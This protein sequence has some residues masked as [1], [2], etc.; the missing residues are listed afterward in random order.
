MRKIYLFI[1]IVMLGMIACKKQSFLDDKTS[2]LVDVNAVFSDSAR[3]IA[4]LNR[5]YEEMP[6]IF[7][8][9]RWEGGNTIIGTD[10]AESNLGNP[11]RRSVALYLANYSQ[12]NFP[13]HDAWNTPW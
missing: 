10:D 5:M 8:Y 9:D 7:L 1:A 13:F 3:T 12:E 11:A 2:S 6:F 4:F